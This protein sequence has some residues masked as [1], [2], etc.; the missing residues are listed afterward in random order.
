MQKNI[1]MDIFYITYAELI[2]KY[3]INFF[4]LYFKHD[5][6]KAIEFF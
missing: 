3:N 5:V 6:T 1:N 2:L 4:I